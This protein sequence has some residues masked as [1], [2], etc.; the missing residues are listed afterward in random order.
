MEQNPQ[1][2]KASTDSLEQHYGKKIP[3]TEE[4]AKTRSYLVQSE[5]GEYDITY[6]NFILLRRKRDNTGYFQN[7]NFDGRTEVFFTFHRKKR[8]GKLTETDLF[9]NFVG[10]IKAFFIND[11]QL[12]ICYSNHKIFINTEALENNAVNKVTILFSA[13]YSSSGVGIHHY[14]DPSDFREYLYTQF[15][16]FDCNRVFPAFDQPDM[17]AKMK[18]F[19]VAPAEWTVLSNEFETES[20]RDL[21]VRNLSQTDFT[22]KYQLKFTEEEI[23]FL[24]VRNDIH[25]KDYLFHEFVCT[26]KISSYLYALCAGPYYRIKCPYT[27][28]VPLNI[29]LRESLKDKGKINDFFL[30]TIAGMN[31]YKNYFG[32]AYPFRK[33]D[34]IFCP[35]YNMGAMEN[36]GLV[37]YNEFYCFKDPPTK[38][39]MTGFIITVLHELAHMWFGNLVTMVWWDDLWLNE[40]FATFISHLCLAKAPELQEY[41]EMSW[42]LF[43][44]YKG[45]A[46]RADQQ[47]TTHPVMSEIKNTEIAETHFD[48]IVYEKGSS[49]L[50]QIYY[51]ISDEQFSSGLKSYFAQYKW[52]N[53]TFNEFLSKMS[54][55]EYCK[56]LKTLYHINENLQE[57]CDSH[58]KK[59]GLNEVGLK[60][61]IEGDLITR[62]DITQTPCLSDAQHANRQT[63]LIEIIFLN[64]FSDLSDPEN[65]VFRNIIV[66][67]QEVTSIANFLGLKAP[68]AVILNYNDWAYFKWTIDRRSIDN[69]KENLPLIQ[70]NLLKALV[71]RSLFDMMRDSK[72]SGF[73]YV[74]MVTSFI[75]SE[76]SEM[77]LPNLFNNLHSAISNYVPLRFYQE[78][79]SKI[80]SIVLQMLKAQLILLHH[81]AC[82]ASK[83]LVLNLIQRVISFSCTEEHFDLFLKWLEGNQRIDEVVFPENIISQDHRFGMIKRIYQSKLITFEK[84]EQLLHREIGRDNMSDRSVL[85]KFYCYAIRPEKAVKEELWNRFVNEPKSD[86]LY[87]MES[88]MAGFAPIS[89]MDLTLEYTKHRFFEVVSKVA[90]ENDFFFVRSFVECLGPSLYP[91]EEVMFKLEKLSE[92]VKEYD[93]LQKYVLEM[94]DN[95]KRKKKAYDLCE[96]YLKNRKD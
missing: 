49:V 48:E 55:L 92:E 14:T 63:H 61:E 26:D 59:S 4:E 29:Y 74:E 93:T 54:E 11:K 72:I 58:L 89:Q 76:N 37:T 60:M 24:F 45:S 67:P 7:S 90:K 46:Y 31:F 88:M 33:Y 84:K 78:Q 25:G 64:N 95:L 56:K 40:S 91:E 21:A 66:Q 28:D 85:A 70:D 36:V 57:L 82:L 41:S 38:R 13:R 94:I 51:I 96:D 47:S 50:K 19:V 75:V 73:E 69:L 17:K 10:E 77:A 27:C 12:P 65:L 83:D 34:Q 86:S 8:D 39:Q 35:E 30:A 23:D 3:L 32:I 1:N 22:V 9:L 43:N 68:K 71:Y 20:T 6:K 53:T 42:L 52:Q 16:P 80:F 18:L 62:F 5:L 2:I 79:S 87:N 15:E 81:N 44:T